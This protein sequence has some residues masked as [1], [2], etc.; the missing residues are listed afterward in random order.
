M[1]QVAREH[2]FFLGTY[3]IGMFLQGMAVLA[4]LHSTRPGTTETL[5]FSAVMTLVWGIRLGLEFAYPVEVP[6]FTLDRPHTAIAPVLTVIATAF[7]AAT[8][9]GVAIR[10]R[11]RALRY[12][13]SKPTRPN[14]VGQRWTRRT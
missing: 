4:F 14:M 12:Y 11:P 3:A 1:T 9:A 10:T 2:F 7:A 8:L 5:A 13:L 6:I